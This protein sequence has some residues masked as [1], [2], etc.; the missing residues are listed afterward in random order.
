MTAV[1]KES[2]PPPSLPT[3]AQLLTKSVAGGE[4]PVSM[5]T[6]AAAKVATKRREGRC[7]KRGGTGLEKRQWVCHAWRGAGP[8]KGRIR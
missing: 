4:N 3:A 7:G 2:A 6:V 5:T 8:E 1:V